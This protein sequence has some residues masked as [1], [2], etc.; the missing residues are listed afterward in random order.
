MAVILELLRVLK[1]RNNLMLF[2]L[3]GVLLDPVADYRILF[4]LFDIIVPDVIVLHF[5]EVHLPLG[6]LVDLLC[7]KVDVVLRRFLDGAHLALLVGGQI[8]QG[9]RL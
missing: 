6:V 8:T 9:N 7:L 3:V 2:A 5:P 1:Y 4:L